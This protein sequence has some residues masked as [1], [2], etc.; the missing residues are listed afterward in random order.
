MRPGKASLRGRT[1]PRREAYVIPPRNDA[2][3]RSRGAPVARKQRPSGWDCSAP[4]AA[5]RAFV[6]RQQKRT[7]FLTAP[8]PLE[9][10]RQLT[11]HAV[12]WAREC[13]RPDMLE[14]GGARAARLRP[15]G[16]A[17][18]SNVLALLE[19]SARWQQALGFAVLKQQQ[20]Q[21]QQ[22][23]W[24]GG[25]HASCP[26]G[27]SSCMS[28]FHS[29]G[30]EIPTTL[31]P[32]GETP[33]LL[34]R[35]GTPPL[36]GVTGYRSMEV[37]LLI[38]LTAAADRALRPDEYPPR[39]A[40]VDVGAEGAGEAEDAQNDEQE[41]G[42]EEE[43]EG[44][45][46]EDGECRNGSNSN[47]NALHRPGTPCIALVTT[48]GPCDADG[49]HPLPPEEAALV[50]PWRLQATMESCTM[51]PA[52]LAFL[53]AVAHTSGCDSIASLLCTT[54][55]HDR[56]AVPR[57]PQEPLYVSSSVRRTIQPG[58]PAMTTC[59]AATYRVLRALRVAALP[60]AFFRA[61]KDPVLLAECVPLHSRGA[62]STA[63]LAPVTLLAL[64]YRLLQLRSRYAALLLEWDHVT[65]PR[66]AADAAALQT[67]PEA[68]AATRM[69]LLAD[70][71]AAVTARHG[72]T[73]CNAA[74][75]RFLQALVEALDAM[76][77]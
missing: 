5:A 40:D 34:L 7:L 23:G 37:T 45:E 11:P 60:L 33:A 12:T 16:L 24:Q 64:R 17:T 8:S 14:V 6:Q 25:V 47:E 39:S 18:V 56:M 46:E 2:W 71:T 15:R 73:P 69:L 31:L 29:H 72:L 27:A 51:M 59:V 1:R 52:L 49:S 75:L 35:L 65:L 66:D 36:E 21:Q 58:T 28:V 55:L 77:G 54:A 48:H 62:A 50:E 10:L 30:Q 32:P 43:E 63:A 67:Q 70:A 9:L 19:S 13:L 22:K 38:P 74:T 53:N 68:C 57:G 26:P 42:W 20:Q 61:G 44:E 76:V 4:Q 3:R 41:E